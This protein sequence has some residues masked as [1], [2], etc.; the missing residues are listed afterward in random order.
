VIP[1]R[2]KAGATASGLIPNWKQ[3]TKSMQGA[4]G[5]KP[6]LGGLKDSDAFAKR[7]KFQ[8]SKLLQ[9]IKFDGTQN[10]SH[11][12]DVS[13]RLVKY[14]RLSLLTRF[15]I[16]CCYKKPNSE[17]RQK[18]PQPPNVCKVPRREQQPRVLTANTV[19]VTDLPEFTQVDSKWRKVFVPSLYNVLFQLEAPFKDFILG[20]ERFISIVQKVVDCVYPE[21]DYTVKR[22]EPI[23]LLV[24]SECHPPMLHSMYLFK[25]LQPYQ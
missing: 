7:P 13:D 12:N 4:E 9:A 6:A 24:R 5:L 22:D 1:I 10:F 21:V 3:H 14:Q 23:H 20:T 18:K 25:G 2:L 8:A 11:K 19:R 16:E 17:P 15:S